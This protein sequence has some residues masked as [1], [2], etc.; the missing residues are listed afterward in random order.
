MR[1][2]AP[3]GTNDILPDAI[4]AWRAL[5]AAVHAICHRYGYQEIRTPVLE[6][7]RLFQRSVGEATDIVEKQMFTIATREETED[8]SDSLTLRPEITAPVV[9]AMVEHDMLKQRGFWKLYYVGPAFR[10]ERPQK[11]RLRQFH[12]FGV[13]AVGSHDPLVDAESILLLADILR[14]AGVSKFEVR[15]N[16]IG[17]EACR[18]AYR[19]AVRTA[20]Q[21]R[22]ERLCSDCRRRIDRNVLRVFDC[23]VEGC[24]TAARELPAIAEYLCDGCRAHDAGVRGALNDSLPIRVDTTLVRG[25]DYYTRTVY[26]FTSP[27][28]GAQDALGGG[29]RYND[30]V[31][32]LGG[33]DAGAVGFAAGIERMLIAIQASG[34]RVAPAPE[35]DVYAVSVDGGQRGL[36]FE[37][38]RRLRDR[39]LSAT[40]DFEGRSLKAQMRSADKL[41]ARFALILGPEEAARRVVKVKNLRLQADEKEVEVSIDDVASMLAGR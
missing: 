12:Q 20:A 8:E 35:L 18:P 6:H 23:K 34:S 5:E 24:K 22:V 38:L 31:R 7:T 15:L 26:E 3:R 25:L 21:E 40:M 1:L 11:G 37:V 27:L 9:R 39:G 16:S 32:H 33:P 14:A 19:A 30:L 13:E 2:T 29:G 36:L 10:K 28:L 4:P 17:C 41:N